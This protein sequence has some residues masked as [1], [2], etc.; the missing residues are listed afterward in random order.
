MSKKK[1]PS[2]IGTGTAIIAAEKLRRRCYSLDLDPRY[3]QA[4]VTRW[5]RYS[6]KRAEVHRATPP[7]RRRAR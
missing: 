3:V 5:E 4:A 1:I 6:G 7:T 2:P